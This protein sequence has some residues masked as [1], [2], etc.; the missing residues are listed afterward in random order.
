MSCDPIVAAH[1][2]ARLLHNP[3]SEQEWVRAVAHGLAVGAV[4]HATA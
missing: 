1:L 2:E 4:T 3:D